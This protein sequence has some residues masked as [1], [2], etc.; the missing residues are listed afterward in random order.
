MKTKNVIRNT[1]EEAKDNPLAALATMG[2]FGGS[3]REIE[4]SEARGQE[5][6]VRS[7]VL[8]SKMSPTDRKALEAAGV[9]FGD[10]VNGDD[11]FVH[12][13][14]P[15]GWEKRRTNHSMWSDLVDD[16]GRKRAA[17]F[18]KAAF[19]DRSAHLTTCNRH[20]IESDYPEDGSA[21]E[22]SFSRRFRVMVDDTVLFDT[23][24]HAPPAHRTWETPARDIATAWLNEH[25]PGWD[26]P[27]RYWDD[28]TAQPETGR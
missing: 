22:R 7:E 18:Y 26:D 5:E 9:V 4:E 19:Y 6:L 3:G 16:K 24:W 28:A 11:I 13:K 15:A 25:R 20:R 14:L 23:G 17:I 10:P 8:P 21:L 1:S 27:A 2:A 12:V